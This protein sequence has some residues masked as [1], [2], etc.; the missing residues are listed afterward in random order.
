[1]HSLMHP[2][3]QVFSRSTPSTVTCS[4]IHAGIE[5]DV[6]VNDFLI[7]IT[8]PPDA[9]YSPLTHP[10]VGPPLP[11]N[12]WEVRALVLPMTKDAAASK[13]RL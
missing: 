9:R 2:L 12:F 3:I 1:M 8:S 6:V 13:V 5:A 10:P 7:A 11:T 4:L